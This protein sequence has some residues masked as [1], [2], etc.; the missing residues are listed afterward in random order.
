MGALRQTQKG[1]D[2]CGGDVPLLPVSRTDRVKILYLQREVQKLRQLPGH[3]EHVLS[4]LEGTGQD[5]VSSEELIADF[6]QGPEGH[7]R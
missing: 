7:C 6:S 5:L 2:L 3:A 1:P 4:L